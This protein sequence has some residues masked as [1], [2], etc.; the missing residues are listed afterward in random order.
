MNPEIRNFLKK[1][2]EEAGQKDLTPALE[3]EMINDLNARLE[4]RLILTAMQHLDQDGQ[5]ELGRMAEKKEDPAKIQAFLQNKIPDFNTV[6]ASALEEFRQTYL[7]A[8]L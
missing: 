3:E 2:L 8:Q 4:D 6:F 7:G 5:N 1:L